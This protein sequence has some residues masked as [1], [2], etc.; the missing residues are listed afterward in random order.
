[1]LVDEVNGEYGTLAGSVGHLDF[2]SVT[3]HI[4]KAEA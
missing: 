3:E 1:M 4:I 2:V